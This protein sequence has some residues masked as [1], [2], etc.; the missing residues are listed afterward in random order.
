MLD[1]S[2]HSLCLQGFFLVAA[3]SA[4]AGA[5]QVSGPLAQAV[6]TFAAEDLGKGTVAVDGPWQ[7]HLGDDMAW[8]NPAFDDSHWEQLTA[9]KPWGAQGHPNNG[10]FAWY[11]RHIK[12]TLASGAEPDLAMFVD[13]VPD[14]YELYWNGRFVGGLG[15]LPPHAVLLWWDTPGQTFG[16]GKALGGVL[17]VRFWHAPPLTN[18][19]SEEGGFV[20]PPELGRPESI[21]L[22]KAGYDYS[23]MRG[24]LFSFGLNSLYALAGLLSFLAWLRD[25]KQFLLLWMTGFCLANP[26]MLLTVESP[27]HRTVA[28]LIWAVFDGI[29]DVSLWLLLLELLRLDEK[30]TLARLV[31]GLAC[32]QLALWILDYLTVFPRLTGS[33][34]WIVPLQ[35]V[36]YILTFTYTLL[37]TL[38]LALVIYAIV[39]RRKLDTA[40]WLVAFFAFTTGT[41]FSLTDAAD[42]F[43]QFTRISLDDMVN[44][45]LFTLRGSPIDAGTLS[46]TLLLLAIIH[47]V[48]R[49]SME[50]HRRQSQLEQEFKNAR[51]LQRVLIPEALPEIPGFALTSA[52]KPALEVG[53]DFFQIIPATQGG[54]LIVLGD[55]SGKGLKA[56]MAVSL[57]VGTIRTLADFTKG[58]AA[59]LAGL[60]N[61]LHGRLQG[62]FATA[63]AIRLEPNGNCTLA[64]AGHL[65]PFLNGHE[66]ELPGALPLG[67]TP[68]NSYE[69]TSISLGTGERLTLYTDGLPEARNQTGQLYGFERLKTLVASAP[70]AA[71]AIQVAVA[72]GQEDD[73]TVLTLTRLAAGEESTAQHSA[74]I[75]SPA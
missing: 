45:T 68:S 40:R 46:G 33:I 71:E 15:K 30:P 50:E 1:R 48:Y 64:C 28:Q 44:A 38:P 3:A 62:G 39:C 13:N 4:V 53:G 69:E 12:V 19:T 51:E 74:P 34:R 31:R 75:L 9:D 63:I 70:T 57:I 26:I 29:R 16:L 23:R 8:A 37:E 67:L 11:R 17:A 59:I 5:E 6:P 24:Q 54:T 47:A 25:R 21:A 43:R 35:G 20:Y 52:Y 42:Q 36:D 7:F 41:I 22:L 2:L 10:G 32:F 66:I 14:C 60:S 55:V 65:P 73:I 61:R 72:F 58:P 27:V 56:A 49:S 18:H